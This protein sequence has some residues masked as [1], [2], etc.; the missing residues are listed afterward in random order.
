VL[1][2]GEM[3]AIIGP[4]GAGK[5]TMMDIITGKTR[6]DTAK[7]SSTARSTSHSTTRPRSPTRHRPQ[8]PEADRVR[9]PHRRGQPAA[10]AQGQPRSIFS[11]A[12]STAF[13]HAEDKARIEEILST[14]RLDERKDD[15]AANLSATARSSGWRSACC[16]RRSR[17]YCWSTSRS[18]A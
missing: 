10:G 4:N 1:E 3:R 7:S 6:P 13:D 9:E 16:W 14:V 8:V 12:V 5:T 15:L 17:S 2:P 18:P 11:D